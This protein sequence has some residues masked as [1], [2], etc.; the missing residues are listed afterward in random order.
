MTARWCD[1]MDEIG[2]KGDG[3]HGWMIAL[4][5]FDAHLGVLKD[6]SGPSSGAGLHCSN[7]ER[8]DTMTAHIVDHAL[9][10]NGFLCQHDRLLCGF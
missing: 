10:L 7:V 2:H 5:V 3:F 8:P 1:E 6:R 9:F 4:M